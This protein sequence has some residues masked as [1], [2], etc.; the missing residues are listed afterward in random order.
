MGQGIIVGIS[1]G[2]MFCLIAEALLSLQLSL[3][4]NF[5]SSSSTLRAAI[6]TT[7]ANRFLVLL[8]FK[9]YI[10]SLI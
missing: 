4:F 1:L 5:N 9:Y 10:H 7:I 3:N 2:P 8:V 6:A